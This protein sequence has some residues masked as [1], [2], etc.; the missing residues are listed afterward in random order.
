[1][2][3]TVKNSNIV[4]GIGGLLLGLI[5]TCTFSNFG[6]DRHFMMK[7]YDREVDMHQMSDGTMM[8]NATMGMND[9]MGSMVAEL[10]GKTGDAFDKAFLEEMV[11][12]HQGAVIMA[13]AVLKTSKRPELLNL[14]NEIISAQTKEIEMM[15]TWHKAWFK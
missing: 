15:E 8:K 5:L 12:H 13:E 9:T 11:M 14:A 10:E 7:K 6:G 3:N 1:M 4:Y 2:E